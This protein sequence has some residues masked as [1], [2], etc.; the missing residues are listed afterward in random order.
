MIWNSKYVSLA[1]LYHRFM[2][3]KEVM[4]H[5]LFFYHVKQI[6][7]HLIL[8]FDFVFTLLHVK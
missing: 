8:E 5:R 7:F 6:S 2:N 1:T 3:I 4:K